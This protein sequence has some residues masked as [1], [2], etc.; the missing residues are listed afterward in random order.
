MPMWEQ[1]PH[2]HFTGGTATPLWPSP[3][4]SHAPVP[5]LDFHRTR[6]GRQD[7]YRLVLLNP[8]CPSGVKPS[9]LIS[10]GKHCGFSMSSRRIPA[11]YW[12]RPSIWCIKQIQ[13]D[14]CLQLTFPHICLLS[15]CKIPFKCQKLKNS[16]INFISTKESKWFPFLGFSSWW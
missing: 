2:Q 7:F 12:A 5:C 9:W 3:P 4:K 1:D 6:K 13:K 16:V 14:I 15:Y 8:R 11:S 10:P